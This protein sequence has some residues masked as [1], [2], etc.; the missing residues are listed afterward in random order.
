MDLLGVRGLLDDD[1]SASELEVKKLVLSIV[2]SSWSW[3][4]WK[5]WQ[6]TWGGDPKHCSLS[7]H[8]A[9]RT[10]E[11]IIG[12]NQDLHTSW[13]R[14]R[15]GKTI[16]GPSHPDTWLM[17]TSPPF[18]RSCRSLCAKTSRESRHMNRFTPQ[19]ITLTH[20]QPCDVIVFDPEQTRYNITW[21]CKLTDENFHPLSKTSVLSAV[22]PN[23][24]SG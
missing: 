4:Q 16:T 19:A 11:Q 3:T 13:D 2:V 14:K 6:W 18:G 24:S 15:A 20:T 17:W 12:V 21:P 23:S 5:L 7:V 10:A 8:G 9:F 1:T 22:C